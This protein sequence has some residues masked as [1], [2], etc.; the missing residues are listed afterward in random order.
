MMICRICRE[1]I[2]EDHPETIY[3]WNPETN[4]KAIM[5]YWCALYSYEHLT[6]EQKEYYL[7]LD[8]TNEAKQ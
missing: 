7:S 8:E 6:P 3:T 4:R 1:S 2:E 5:H